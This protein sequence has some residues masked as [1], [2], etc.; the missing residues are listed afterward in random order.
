MT[1]RRFPDATDKVFPAS[2]ETGNGVVY[3]TTCLELDTAFANRFFAIMDN[4]Y[5]WFNNPVA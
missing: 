3:D 5:V 4:V 1:T 2:N